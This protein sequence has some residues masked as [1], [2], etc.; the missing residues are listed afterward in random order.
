MGNRKF[1]IPCDPLDAISNE[2]GFDW[3]QPKSDEYNFANLNENDVKKIGEIQWFDL[4]KEY[5][6]FGN[7]KST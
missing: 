1:L 3:A 5:D 7:L 2:Y 6:F 4:F